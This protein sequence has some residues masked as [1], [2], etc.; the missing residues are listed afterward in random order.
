MK[1]YTLFFLSLGGVLFSGYLSGVKFFTS[2]CALKE[3]CPFF[4]GYPACYYGFA[5]YLTLFIFSVLLLRGGG[6]EVWTRR[7]LLV[8]GLG[9]LFSGYFTLGELPVLWNEGIATFVLGLPTCAWG[10]LMY[11]AV[12]LRAKY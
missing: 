2:S 10:L 8:S 3:S 7:I 6:A 11:I 9:I 5:M 4:L 12:F 1:Y